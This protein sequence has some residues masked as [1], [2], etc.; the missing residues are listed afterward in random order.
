MHQVSEAYQRI[1]QTRYRVDTA[2]LIDPPPGLWP[3]I[4]ADGMPHTLS[5]AQ[6]MQ[7]NNPQEPQDG[8]AYREDFIDTVTTSGEIFG[9]DTKQ[10]G[11][12]SAR[13]VQ[14]AMK[15]P[16]QVIPRRGRIVPLLRI[17]N[18][19][20]SSEWIPK[21][22]F[23]VDTRQTEPGYED[24]VEFV[25]ITGY[26]AMM[27]AEQD[28][29]MPSRLQWPAPDYL[30]LQEIAD[31]M[32]VPI[33]PETLAM[34]DGRVMVPNPEWFCCRE[35]LSGIGAGY[36]GNL[37]IDDYGRLK[38]IRLA[39]PQGRAMPQ[40][41]GENADDFRFAEAWE[42]FARVELKTGED[43]PTW[44]A[45]TAS[46]RTLTVECPW[47]IA[48]SSQGQQM[49]NGILQNIAGY[50]YQPMTAENAVIDP[51]V[52]LGDS[53]TVAG[54]TGRMMA[55]DLDFGEVRSSNIRAPGDEEVDHEFQFKSTRERR[56]TRTTEMAR[57][58]IAKA[59][60]EAEE[61]L[62]K[63]RSG[64]SESIDFTEN[65]DGTLHTA[66]IRT[67]VESA[68]EDTVIDPTTGQERTV[69][70]DSIL[71]LLA[72]KDEKGNYTSLASIK[73]TADGASAGLN[74]KA[75][76][77]PVTGKAGSML[78]LFG[79]I[80][81]T[82]GRLVL[83]DIF[84]VNPPSGQQV[85]TAGVKGSMSVGGNL[86]VGENLTLPAGSQINIGAEA[87]TP[88]DIT[89]YNPTNKTYETRKALGHK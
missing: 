62:Y 39:Q 74:A 85:A 24:G 71:E 45:G 54:M 12:C 76:T 41:I 1:L 22:E 49:A 19:W 80:I 37:S 13:T 6:L 34:M 27:R 79:D 20:E 17:T 14:L 32:G 29:P 51:A 31:F 26:D 36:A 43:G 18:D 21:G 53:L 82:S 42:P 65:P 84:F 81:K 61:R 2:L 60:Q 77:N 28:Y 38:L 44:T 89:S 75:Y 11:V 78:E 67:A 48:D 50:V 70:A 23:F 40:N 58:G 88:E 35:V 64:L 5:D 87:F 15:K 69:L 9:Q 7:Y 3:P 25:E 83:S 57:T 16:R 47:E 46:G 8:P 33:E 59:K 68:I 10:A 66:L 4:G 72:V 55:Q 63:F 73:A 30:V 52:E 56:L 86:N